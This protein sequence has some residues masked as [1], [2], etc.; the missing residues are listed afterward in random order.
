[1][2]GKKYRYKQE[3]KMGGIMAD[4]P[5]KE[6]RENRVNMNMDAEGNPPK[7]S[8][9]DHVTASVSG[10]VHSVG[11]GYDGKGHSVELRKVHSVHYKAHKKKKTMGGDIAKVR[12]TESEPDEDD[13]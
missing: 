1:L 3:V 2:F 8:V 9:G 7:I 10:H 12:G 4:S 11:M 13:M 5:A 6:K